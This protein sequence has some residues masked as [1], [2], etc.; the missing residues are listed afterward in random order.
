MTK[1]NRRPLFHSQIFIFLKGMDTQK[2]MFYL[3]YVKSGIENEFVIF[4]VQ[5]DLFQEESRHF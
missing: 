3:Y 4:F 1:E 2:Y 5:F